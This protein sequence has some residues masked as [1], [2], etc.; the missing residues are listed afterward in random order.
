M[1]GIN[2]SYPETHFRKPNE[3]CMELTEN[4]IN[5]TNIKKLFGIFQ[6]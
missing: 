6:I 2:R 1:F 3:V 5:N 4:G